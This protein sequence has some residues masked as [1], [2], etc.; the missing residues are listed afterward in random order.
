MMSNPLSRNL[1]CHPR[2][3][4]RSIA[5]INVRVGNATNAILTLAFA[6][7]GDLATLRSPVER[8]SRQLEELWRHTCFEAFLMAGNGP[9]YR[10]YNFSPSGEWAAFAF[11]DYRQADDQQAGVAANEPAPVI[12][13]HRGAQ[14]LALEA[15][16]PLEPSPTACSIRLGLSAVVESVDGRLSYWALRHPPGK[17]DFHHIDAFD[18][19]LDRS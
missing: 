10:E 1:V 13:V 2:T 15:D 7:Q 14:H 16:L 9:G 12:R 8:P 3:P 5:A 19:Q 11:R 6:L 17:P 18:L 4:C